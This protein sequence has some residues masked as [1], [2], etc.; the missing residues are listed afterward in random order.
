MQEKLKCNSENKN[1]KNSNKN[2][3]KYHESSNTEVKSNLGSVELE[4]SN[5]NFNKTCIFDNNNASDMYFDY[6]FKLCF[7]WR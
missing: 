5:L 4:I 1:I 3:N 6:L 2:Y 7:F